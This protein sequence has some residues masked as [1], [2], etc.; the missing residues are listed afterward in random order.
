MADK[1]VH[2][3]EYKSKDLKKEATREKK[4]RK[5]NLRDIKVIMRR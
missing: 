2:D 3:L 5:E 4:V 1:R